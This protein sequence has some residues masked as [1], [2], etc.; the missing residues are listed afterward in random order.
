[1]IESK[2]LGIR[3]I[4]FAVA[5]SLRQ[6]SCSESDLELHQGCLDLNWQILQVAQKFQS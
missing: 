2:V 5:T 4:P 6:F 1:M 3:D